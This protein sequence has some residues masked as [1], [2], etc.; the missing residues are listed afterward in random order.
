VLR[1]CTEVSA[2]PAQAYYKLASAERNLH[3]MEAAQRDMKIFLTLS[4][5]PQ[6]GPFPRQNIF[7]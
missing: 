5:N 6:P 7:D 4:K 2:T 1:H 3:Q